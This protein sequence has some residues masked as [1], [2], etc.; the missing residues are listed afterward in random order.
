MRFKWSNIRYMVGVTALTAL[1][2]CVEIPEEDLR[3]QFKSTE[4]LLTTGVAAWADRAENRVEYLDSTSKR[5]LRFKLAPLQLTHAIDLPSGEGWRHWLSSADGSWHLVTLRNQW[6]VIRPQT[7]AT[8]NH[9]S[10]NG[11]I[12]SVVIEPT[13]QILVIRDSQGR[14]AVV[15]VDSQGTPVTTFVATTDLDNSRATESM[16]M[17]A[18]G[19]LLAGT[20]D[21][22]FAK[23][24]LPKSLETQ[25]WV[26]EPFSVADTGTA[27]TMAP[28]PGKSNLVLMRNKSGTFHVINLE[29]NQIVSSRDV[30]N[31]TLIGAWLDVVPHVLTSEL[32]TNAATN[33]NT[34]QMT[35]FWVDADG[36]FKQQTFTA[37]TGQI[38][39]SRMA[40]D[41]SM[42]TL[43]TLQSDN[44][45]VASRVDLRD[46]TS[47]NVS[48]AEWTRQIF[49]RKD[50]WLIQFD[51]ALGVVE[52]RAKDSQPARLEGFNLRWLRDRYK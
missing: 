52:W 44:Q 49:P 39:K 15:R 40:E 50:G 22:G 37:P 6:A 14:V 3:T 32:T 1:T 13:E 7:S 51:S 38:Q 47:T 30:S 20:N 12:E 11:T 26:W 24:D 5:L 10:F 41:H 33:P 45:M 27:S 36:T 17:L 46:P 8:V 18:G 19:I 21:G 4:S 29:T 28:I 43:V 9:V 34:T 35:V 2:S 48:P 42:L 25:T 23:I 16:A 31:A